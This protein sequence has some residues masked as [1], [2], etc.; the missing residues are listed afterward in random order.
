[1]TSEITVLAAFAAG[2]LSFLSP[3]VL[4]LVPAYISYMS[5]VSLEQLQNAPRL[6]ARRKTLLAAMAFI[7]GFSVVFVLLGATATTLGKL[8]LAQFAIISKIAGIVIILLGLHFL[9]VFRHFLRFLNYEKRFHVQKIEPGMAGAFV[10][11]LAFAFGWTPCIG[12]I[13]SVIL[14]LAGAQETVW[15][16]IWLLTAYSL[17]LGVPFLLTALATQTFLQLLNRVKR[18][19]GVLEIISG[20]FLIVVG[21][22]MFTGSFSII[23]GKMIEWFPWLLQFS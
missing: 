5:G 15:Q 2:I 14:A 11:G 10:V 4:P 16:G 13:L 12:P 6:D 21:G 23:A 19:F 22:L 3:C 18:Y 17:G 7:L 8:L 1:M 9:G 20:V